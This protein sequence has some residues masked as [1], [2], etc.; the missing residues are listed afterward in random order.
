MTDYNKLYEE[1]EMVARVHHANKMY[2]IYPYIKHVL[3]VVEVL[4]RHGYSGDDLIAGALHDTI[5][6][7]DLTYNKINKAFGLVVAEIVLACTDPSDLRN[8]KEKK[9]RMLE[10]MKAY[11]RAI[12]VKLADRVANMAHSI[13]M[14]NLD[15]VLMYMKEHVELEFNLRTQGEHDGLWND[16]NTL[17]GKGRELLTVKHIKY[18]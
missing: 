16:L 9:I 1:A 10:K 18:D 6:D 15:K 14:Q 4:K 5:E 2:D 8:R 12:P 3:D 11:P 17:F 13:R 7:S